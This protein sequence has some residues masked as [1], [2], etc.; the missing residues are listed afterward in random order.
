LEIPPYKLKFNQFAID[1]PYSKKWE[2][3]NLYDILAENEFYAKR[4]YSMATNPAVDNNLRF[5]IR[6]AFPPKQKNVSAG[7]GSSYVYSLKPND[8]VNISEPYGDFQVQETEKEKL[9]IGGGAGMAPLRSHISH[10]FETQKTEQKV[11][12]WYGARSQSELYYAD[13]FEKLEKNYDNFS[14]NVAL[15]NL[16]KDDEWDGYVGF[17][18]EIVYTEYLK[19][20][21]AAAELEYYLCGP[22]A[23]V[24]A[25]RNMLKELKIP[26][27]QIF[28]D[29]F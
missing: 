18:H 15:S 29:E 4:N 1:A 17:I 25:C 23:M 24:N 22:P 3:Q 20:H 6:I 2:E 8:I 12:Y 13:Y 19:N 9:Y 27:E 21:S 10:L 16:D 14:F 5:N 28:Y 11:T 26:V 7:I